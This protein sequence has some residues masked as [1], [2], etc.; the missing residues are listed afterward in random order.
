M[1]RHRVGNS[2]ISGLLPT[3]FAGRGVA[4][5]LDEPRG[6][7][8]QRIDLNGSWERHF[9]DRPLDVVTVP[10]SLRPA[11]YYQLKRKFLMPHLSPQQRAVLHFEAITYHGRVFIN[12]K[13]LG[14]MAPYVPHEFDIT[15]HVKEGSNAIDV[16]I[17]D[18]RP[19]P[20]GAG[21]DEIDFGVAIGWE[22]YGGIIR[23]VY[24]EIRPAAFIDNVRFGYKLESEYRRAACRAQVYVSSSVASSGDVA[25]LTS[26]GKGSDASSGRG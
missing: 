5:P 3:I 21:K 19:D 11:G 22:V 18:I 23:D 10:S 20:S 4:L 13:E 1:N 17:V 7:T 9:G 25:L 15:P 2:R 14:T 8:R 12:G 26:S 16:A 24:V 6:E